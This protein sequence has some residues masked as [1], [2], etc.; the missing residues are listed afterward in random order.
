MDGKVV[1]ISDGDTIKVLDSSN[2]EWKVRLMG[3]DAPEKRQPFGTVS[4]QSLSELVYMKPVKIEWFKKD[5][6]KR[7]VGKVLAS[8]K[9]INLEQIQRGFAWHYKK[10]QGEQTPE[11]RE[12]Y[13]QAE[14]NAQK[15]RIGLWG[16]NSAVP[17]LGI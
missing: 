17:P 2:H 12:R 7:I 16:D 4:K 5:R 3:I 8:N 10:Y 9:D 14:I 13:S 1:G 6:Y 11:D 15:S